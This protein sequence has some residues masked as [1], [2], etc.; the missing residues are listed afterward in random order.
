MFIFRIL[1]KPFAIIASLI[2]ARVGKRTFKQLWSNLS[3]EE[4]PK[5]TTE[6]AGY[7]KV[8]VAAAVQAATL[9]ATNAAADRASA[10][11]FHYLT[12]FWPGPKEKAPK[13]EKGSEV[14]KAPAA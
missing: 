11:V 13:E 10:H 14:E 8:M 5:P 6:D 3:D 4:P 1:Y 12:G 7:T 2:A 9:A